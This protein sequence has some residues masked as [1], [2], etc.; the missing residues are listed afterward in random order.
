MKPVATVT[1]RDPKRP[2]KYVIME[3]A[4]YM[5]FIREQ[6]K[7]IGADMG[8]DKVKTAVT[9]HDCS[10]INHHII[11]DVIHL[12]EAMRK[13]KEFIENGDLGGLF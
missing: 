2:D 11:S 13:V 3:V 4:D 9:C 7:I 5:Q 8:S 1:I 12:E 10:S 6:A